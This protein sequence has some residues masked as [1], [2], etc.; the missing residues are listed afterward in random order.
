MIASGKTI[1]MSA[2]TVREFGGE[3][4]AVCATHGLFV[5]NAN[6]YLKGI[7][8]IV[9]SDSV[10]PFR[11]DEI[12]K[13]LHVIPTVGLFAQAIKRTHEHGSISSLLS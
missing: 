6:E 8:N 11:L 3:V 12:K 13:Q 1:K 9:I 10:Q 4:W 7:P 5:G 2:D